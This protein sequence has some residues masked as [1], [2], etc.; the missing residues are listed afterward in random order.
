MIQKKYDIG[1]IG[2]GVM[3]R[4][5]LLNMA[6]HGYSVVGYDK[7]QEQVKALRREAG[8]RDVDAVDNIEDLVAD[9]KSPKAIIMLVPAGPPV[10]SVIKEVMPLLNEDDILIDG[11]NSHYPDTE[12]RFDALSDKGFHYFGVG[13]SGGEKGARYGPSM[14]P[15]G[16]KEAYQRIKP[17]FEAVAAK[18][19]GESCVTYLGP[20]SAGH[21]VKMVHNG[22]E[23]GIMQLISESY[24]LLKRGL[25][26]E[27]DKLHKIFDQWNQSELESYLI[28]ITANIFMQKDEETGKRLID[29]IEP[30]ARQKGTG[31]WTSQDALDLQVPVPTIDMAVVMRNMS[32]FEEQRK[33][34]SNAL[35]GPEKIIQGDEEEFIPALHQALLAGMILAFAQ[36]MAQLRVA[37]Q[38]KEYGLDLEAVA[39]IWRGGCIIRAALLDD[40]MMAYQTQPELPNLLL[41]PGFSQTLEDLQPALRRVVKAGVESGIPTPAFM[42][43]LAYFDSYRSSWQ[44]ANL[45]QAQRDYFGSHT[46]ERIDKKGKFHTEWEPVEEE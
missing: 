13:I 32:T 43:S 14:M 8:D 37:S 11:G 20:R 45:I 40:I 23:Y 15:G 35:H 12:K 31:M 28:E 18:V 39:R 3:G 10:D 21:Y 25:G 36:G 1:M 16:Q 5:L 17:I 7:A 33:A 19:N 26:I 9:I 29:L 6:D 24:D 46:Y 42:A 44:P 27:N 4:N 38:Q 41:D 34:A 30:V 22:I 2:L